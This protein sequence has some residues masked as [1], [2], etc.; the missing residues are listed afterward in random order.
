[1]KLLCNVIDL[2]NYGG[3]YLKNTML[4]ETNSC[5]RLEKYP[6]SITSL[7]AEA[8]KNICQ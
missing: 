2:I 1:M 8:V 7:K 6:Y 3:Q 5:Y 4:K